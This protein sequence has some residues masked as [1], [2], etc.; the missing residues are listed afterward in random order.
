MYRLKLA[1]GSFSDMISLTACEGRTRCAR[2]PG[3]AVSREPESPL[4]YVY[5]GQRCPGH[6]LQR[7]KLGYEAFAA[8]DKSAG[9]FANPKEAAK[10]LL[11]GES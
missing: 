10:A 3:A 8:D 6:L 2:R 11:G 4:A 9:I 5:D 7:G 1:D